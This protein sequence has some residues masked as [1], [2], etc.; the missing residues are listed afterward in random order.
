MILF[1]CGEFSFL[2]EKRTASAARIELLDSVVS[3]AAHI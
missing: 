3:N 2:S 1:S